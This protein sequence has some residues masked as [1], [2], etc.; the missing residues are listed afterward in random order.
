MGTFLLRFVKGDEE[1]AKIIR[2][3]AVASQNLKVINT[4]LE[5]TLWKQVLEE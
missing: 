3:I 2:A 1:I 4:L 5:K